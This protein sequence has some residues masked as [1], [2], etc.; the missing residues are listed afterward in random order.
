PSITGTPEGAYYYDQLPQTYDQVLSA[1]QAKNASNGANKM[2]LIDY[3]PSYQQINVE[4]PSSFYGYSAVSN[5]EAYNLKRFLVA[6]AAN[7]GIP[8]S[9]KPFTLCGAP[10]VMKMLGLSSVFNLNG[11]TIDDINSPAYNAFVTL[12]G[13]D[14]S[15]VIPDFTTYPIK[16]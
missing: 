4:W 6:P 15:I 11:H 3:L 7:Y 5:V 8:S 9:W 12:P 1:L 16:S 13:T 10:S 2:A 14:G